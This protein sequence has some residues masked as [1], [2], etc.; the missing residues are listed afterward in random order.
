MFRLCKSRFQTNIRLFM[1]HALKQPLILLALALF[2][3][4]S[5]QEKPADEA[6]KPD[7]K[8]EAAG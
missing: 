5:A 7:T 6:K 8:E 3:P 4:I 2:H 1:T